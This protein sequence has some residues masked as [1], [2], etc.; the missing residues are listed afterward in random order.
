MFVPRFHRQVTSALDP[1]AL[2]QTAIAAMERQAQNRKVASAAFSQLVHDVSSRAEETL[3]PVLESLP[4]PADGFQ[5]LTLCAP[6]L[7]D[8]DD[9][10]PSPGKQQERGVRE[11]AS[12]GMPERGLRETTGT[13]AKASALGKVAELWSTRV[14]PLLRDDD[15]RCVCARAR[16]CV[17]VHP[18]IRAC[19]CVYIRPASVCSVHHS[20]PLSP[21]IKVLKSCNNIRIKRRKPDILSSLPV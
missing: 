10:P 16:A 15:P 2:D 17:C 9:R 20:S 12:P 13:P 18:C 8:L 19:M 6:D 4:L 14:T 3:V 1:D 5:G 11:M 7:E 21:A